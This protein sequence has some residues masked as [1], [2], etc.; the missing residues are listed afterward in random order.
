MFEIT[1]ELKDRIVAELLA[2]RDNFS[3]SD[4]A[5]A[6]SLGINKSVYSTLK[7]GKRDGLLPS[8]KWLNLARQLAIPTS[9]RKWNA[10]RTEVFV[11]IEEDIL[12][13]KEHSKSMIFVDNCGIGKTFTAQYLS[14]KLQNCFYLDCSQCKNA[15]EFIRTLARTIG[16]DSTGKMAAVKADIKYCLNYLPSPVVVCDEAGDLSHEAWLDLKE[17][18]NATPGCGWYLM[19]ADGLRARIDRGRENK[20]VGFAEMFSRLGENYSTVVPNDRQE[21]LEFYRKLITDVLSVN[22]ADK[23]QLKEI[24][25]QCLVVDK[26]TGHVGGL[27]RA[28]SLLILN[29]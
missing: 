9:G 27:R 22:M 12:F 3:G 11:Q 6:T 20:K 25:N 8:A 14:R 18:W 13:C 17:M 7:N 4:A 24:L 23:K 21:K 26:R 19:G 15:R 5:Y 28:E 2:K 16:V 29:S 1:D 10:A